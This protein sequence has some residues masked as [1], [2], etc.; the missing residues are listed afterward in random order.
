MKTA[1][2]TVI[3]GIPTD[4]E[5]YQLD[6]YVTMRYG[7]FFARVRSHVRFRLRSAWWKI[8]DA[9]HSGKP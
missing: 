4:R 8:S 5:L 7:G 9:H 1:D 6:H 2:V 3:T